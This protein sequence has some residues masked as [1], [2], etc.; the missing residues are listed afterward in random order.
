MFCPRCGQQQISDQTRFCS[1]CGFVTTGVAE[2]IANGG[3]LPANAG[4][5]KLPT[6]R[7]KG[8]KQGLFIF[9]LTFLVVPIIAIISALIEIE[10]ALVA[11]ASIVFFV[12]GLLR[13]AY[14]LMFESNNPNE[15]TL[16]QSVFQSAQNIVEKKPDAAALPPTQYIPASGYIPPTQ[17]NWRDTNDLTP[18]TVT[19]NTTKLLNKKE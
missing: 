8:L 14:A 11:I 3:V 17:G 4:E 15:K 7:K 16:E 10:P 9:L 1:R 5:N 18:T 12:G 19:E 2:L 6:P 13:M